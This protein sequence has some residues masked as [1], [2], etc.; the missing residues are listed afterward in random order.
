MI[1]PTPI[2]AHLQSL[3][4]A[5]LQ[6]D[7]RK[8]ARLAELLDDAFFEIG[9]SGRVFTKAQVLDA[10]QAESEVHIEATDFEV[11]FMAPDVAL[12][13][14]RA[15]RLGTPRVHTWRSS[16]WKQAQGQWRMAFHQGTI[17]PI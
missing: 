17:I 1:P 5:L 11:R 4:R 15:H 9:S 2:E 6:P 14:Y 12:V 8:S 10:L 13:T 3:E 16:L 7:V